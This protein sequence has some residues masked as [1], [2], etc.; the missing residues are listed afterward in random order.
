MCQQLSDLRQAVARFAKGFDARCLLGSQAAQV[1]DDTAAIEAMMG[2]VKALAVARVEET[3][4]WGGPASQGSPADELSQRTGISKGQARHLLEAGRRL[5]QAPEVA[6]AALAG[7]LSPAQAD[8][9]AEAAHADPAAAHRLIQTAQEASM[10]ELKDE[11]A[12]TQAAV[13]DL[14]ARRKAI[15]RRRRLRAWTDPEGAWHLHGYGNPEDGAQIMAA[16]APIQN[17]IF[18]HARQQGR[19][20]PPDA[21]AFDSLVELALDARSD[22]H[23]APTTAGGGPSDPEP[24]PAGAGVALDRPQPPAG[25]R[26]QAAPTREQ[27]REPATEQSHDAAGEQSGDPAGE[28]ADLEPTA[29]AE[30]SGD[31]A[32]ETAGQ[33]SEPVAASHPPKGR[34][35]RRRGAPVKLLLRVDYDTW[36]RGVVAPGETCELVGYG[37]IPLSVAHD[38]IQTGDPFVAAILTKGQTLVGVA[39]LGRQPTAYQQ[40]ALEWLYPTCAVKGCPNRARLER[41][42]EIDWSKTHFTMLDH[43]DLLCH[44]HHRQK[45]IHNWALTPGTGKRPFV[46]PEDPRHPRHHPDYQ[47]RPDH[48]A[49]TRPARRPAGDNPSTRPKPPQPAGDNPPTRPNPAPAPGRRRP[50]TSPQTALFPQPP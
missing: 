28:S 11:V 2:A 23:P 14:E 1:I 49:P 6:D 29:G 50:G 40:S 18:H 12:R 7:K 35:R 5:A 43:L 26:V 3:K 34:R 46:P 25:D 39:H 42:H 38:L 8:L 4:A 32:G 19:R 13:T 15:H 33:L 30:Q 47:K 27:S 9:I 17:R 48:I 31:P 45:T 16:L 37:P 41:D 10:A 20:E 24:A 21:Y 44:H 36:L 22:G